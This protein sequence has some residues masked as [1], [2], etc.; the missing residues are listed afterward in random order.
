M[1]IIVEDLQDPA[2]QDPG[3]Y[4]QTDGSVHVILSEPLV[5][6]S[7]DNRR[8]EFL[9]KL[10]RAPTPSECDKAGGKAM[11]LNMYDS[12]HRS[13]LKGISEP[14]IT[15]RIYDQLDAGDVQS[16]ITG[17]CYFLLPKAKRAT[18]EA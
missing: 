17:T 16:L 4:P 3:F 9:V 8:E 1:P 11:L 7:E 13:V 15:P 14:Q 18:L 12:A 2:D 10:H 6:G 5:F